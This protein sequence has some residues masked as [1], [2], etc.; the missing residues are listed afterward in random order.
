MTFVI[1]QA[2]SNENIF[3]IDSLNLVSAEPVFSY[4]E[5]LKFRGQYCVVLSFHVE[6]RSTWQS[7]LKGFP[8]EKY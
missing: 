2:C 7:V 1:P 8:Y 6:D 4:S 3:K 5:I